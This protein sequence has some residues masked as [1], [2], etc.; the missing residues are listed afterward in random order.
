MVWHRVR[1]GLRRVIMLRARVA[2]LCL[3]GKLSLKDFMCFY[4]L[5]YRE[6]YI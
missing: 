2:P 6:I 4:N 5:R 3:L 1:E